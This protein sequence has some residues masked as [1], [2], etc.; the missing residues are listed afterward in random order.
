MRL[1]PWRIGLWAFAGMIG[2]AVIG[3]GSARLHSAVLNWAGF[4]LMLASVL[5]MG[6]AVFR[7]WRQ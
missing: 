3:E 5:V 4:S 7:F 6:V 1:G 2:A